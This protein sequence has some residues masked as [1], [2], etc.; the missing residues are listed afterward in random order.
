VPPSTKVTFNLNHLGYP[1]IPG[2]ATETAKWTADITALGNLTNVHCKLSGLPQSTG[3]KSWTG[4]D[5]VP[6][7]EVVLKA[8][9]PKRVNFAGNWFILDQFAEW[10]AMV[11]AVDQG[12]DALKV[13]VT[14]KAAIYSG[15]A[16][17]LYNLTPHQLP[18][19]KPETP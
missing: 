3:G 15:N 18:D 12:L 4:S 17:A 6:F 14:D 5:F 13:S 11:N 16:A 8:F 9:G 1:D 10:P 19:A 2:N 7:I